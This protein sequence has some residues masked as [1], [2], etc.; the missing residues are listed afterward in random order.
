MTKD[1]RVITTK[2]PE[3]QTH[4][5]AKINHKY[6]QIKILCKINMLLAMVAVTCLP[7]WR[8]SLTQEDM[9]GWANSRVELSPGT[10]SWNRK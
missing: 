6:I 9:Q 2:L 8:P 5:N 7:I 4:N 3:S 10:R 1:T